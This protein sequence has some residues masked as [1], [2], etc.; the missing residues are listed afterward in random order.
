M[1]AILGET[2][3]FGEVSVVDK[4]GYTSASV[5]AESDVV[6]VY[7]FPATFIF[8]FIKT[9]EQGL[10]FRFFKY[11]ATRL[12]QVTLCNATSKLLY[13]CLECR[14]LEQIDVDC[15]L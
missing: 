10:G 6:E 15:D 8:K 2:D 4:Y 5:I 3:I 14:G 1:Q 9:D 12:C 13:T 7:L 11:I